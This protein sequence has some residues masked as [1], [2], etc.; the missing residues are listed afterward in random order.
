MSVHSTEL[1]SENVRGSISLVS[2]HLRAG[3]VVV[4]LLAV[5]GSLAVVAVSGAASAHPVGLPHGSPSL[6]APSSSSSR[7]PGALSSRS[8][9]LHPSTYPPTP[10][11]LNWTVLSPATS[12]PARTG[13][14]E[15]WDGADNYL[16]LFGGKGASGYLADTWRYSAGTWTKLSPTKAPSARAYAS[17][18]YDAYDGYVLLFGGL[19]STGYQS[20]TW[21]FTGGQWINITLIVGTAPSPRSDAAVTFDVTNTYVLLYG[22]Y[23]GQAFLG[24]TWTYLTGTWTQQGPATSPLPMMGAAMVYDPTGSDDV[25]VG[26]VGGFGYNGLCWEW[27][28]GGSPYW[29]DAGYAGPGARANSTIGW[30]WTDIWGV[31]FGGSSPNGTLDDTWTESA[32]AF[33][34]ILPFDTPVFRS[35]ASIAWDPFT[36]SDVLFG[37]NDGATLYSDTW[38]FWQPPPVLGPVYASSSSVDV[39]MYVNFN[40]SWFGGSGN[41]PFFDWTESAPGLGCPVGAGGPE[42]LDCSATIAPGTYTVGVNATD[43]TTGRTGS[44]VTS[45]PFVV[46]PNPSAPGIPVASVASVDS[47]QTVTFT[48]T[49]SSVPGSGGDVYSWYGLPTGC[50]SANSLSLT[51]TPSLT[52]SQ[53]FTVGLSVYDS[54]GG[55]NYSASIPFWVYAD[56]SAPATPTASV[57]AADVGQT[58]AFSSSTSAGG[59]GG[60]NYAWFGLPTGCAS[61]NALTVVCV[62]EG[63][64]AVTTFHVNVTGTDSNGKFVT[65]AKLAF[66]VSPDPSIATP[67][68]TH[69]DVDAGGSTTLSTTS[70]SGSGTPVY[71]WSGL[72]AGC[73]SQSALTLS[74]SPS[75]S[76]SGT[77]VVT[78]SVRDSNGFN[79]TSGPLALQVL[80]ALS[81]PSVTLS[82]STVDVGQQVVLSASVSGGAGG[83]AYAWTAL[84]VGCS[85]SNTPVLLCVPTSV[86]SGSF[87]PAVAV[88]DAAGATGTGTSAD[89]L[90]VSA[91]LSPGTLTATP[92]SLDVGQSSELK[93]TVSG[94]SGGLAYAWTG[95]P[96]G[97]ASTNA[98]SVACAPT[99]PGAEGVLLTVTDSN[100][101]S[102][103]VGPATLEVAP[104]LGSASIAVSS[105]SPT[106]GSTLVFSASVAGGTGPLSYAWSGLP[107]GCTAADVATLACSPTATGASTATVTI[108]DAAGA[109]I[110][111]TAPAVTVGAAPSTS[112]S[113]SSSSSLT[114]GALGVAVL[115]LVLALVAMLMSRRGGEARA[116]PPKWKESEEPSSTSSKASSK[117]EK[118]E[119]D[120]SW[121]EGDAPSKSEK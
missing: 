52:I 20:D 102:V 117:S 91:P 107:V 34:Q 21:E 16:L 75:A 84:P 59:S 82:R 83:Y 88:T 79:A 7:S 47:G 32:G 74:C 110:S 42:V 106:V 12:P 66:T 72:P 94:G 8:H 95:L 19:S 111:A 77:Y 6:S 38:E 109:T 40:V 121:S 115:A 10:A 31:L 1:G 67:T 5:L 92:S 30:D 70:S 17:M 28:G 25:M 65:S 105:T 63:I 100:G 27:I 44:A 71:A 68:A 26:G 80:S 116:S 2:A 58:V 98:A 41:Y 18:A 45:G 33:S 13:A 36:L 23:N 39:G 43:S 56:P 87:T 119:H 108:T 93:G 73:L 24:D 85:A 104:A 64:S 120:E 81:T 86:G 15:A 113:S 69:V 114:D 118:S 49:G 35:N 48:S 4:A 60:T 14:A 97:C 51:C 99:A 103:V 54:N 50:S 61:A 90:T 89:Q 62:P 55:Y 29:F 46:Y 22:G 57:P 78:V 37:G 101:A 11:P 76:A 112:S 96:A 53:F 3:V 9:P